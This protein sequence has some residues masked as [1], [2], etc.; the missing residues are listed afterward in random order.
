MPKFISVSND[1]NE[2]VRLNVDYIFEVAKDK[3]TGKAVIKMAVN[4]FNNFAFY[5]VNTN[6]DYHVVCEIIDNSI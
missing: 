2:D 5:Y 1:K 3:K 6:M 4:G